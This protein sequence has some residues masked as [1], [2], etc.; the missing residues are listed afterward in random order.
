MAS[1]RVWLPAVLCSLVILTAFIG[2]TQ[3]ASCCMMFTSRR[4]PC[5]RL[6]GYTIQTIISSCD[7]NAVIFHLPAKFVC[8]DPS[9]K[10]TLRGMK[11]VDER[12]RKMNWTKGNTT[13]A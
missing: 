5:Q 10:W 6:M 2:S 4:F 13:S 7:I 8:A 12:R 3:S 11:C 1:G 9:S